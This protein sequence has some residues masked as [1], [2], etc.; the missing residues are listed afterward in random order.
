V[1]IPASDVGYIVVAILVSAIVHELGHALAAG[2]QEARVDAVGG[3]LALVFPGAYVQLAGIKNLSPFQQLK[4][5]C[6]GAWHNIVLGIICLTMVPI[7][8]SLL[9]L[10]YERGV[11]AMV[12]SMPEG[13]PLVGHLEAGDVISGLGM[14]NVS[15]GGRSFRSAVAQLVQSG[16]SAGFCISEALHRQYAHPESECCELV[17]RGQEHPRLQCFSV[18]DNVHPSHKRSCISPT[19][20]SNRQTCRVSRDCAGFSAPPSSA[21][22]SGASD[23]VGD[24]G[25]KRRQ[26]LNVDVDGRA[27]T[28]RKEPHNGEDFIHPLSAGEKMG[29][30]PQEHGLGVSSGSGGGGKATSAK[31][32]AGKVRRGASPQRCFVAVLPRGEKLIDIR[33]LSGQSGGVNHFFYQGYGSILGGSVTV[34][35]YVPRSWWVAPWWGR[36]VVAWLDVPN[37]VERQLQ[38]VASMS[39][40]LAVLNMAPVFWLDGEASVELFA[41]MLVPSLDSFRLAQLKSMMLTVGTGL[42]AL[43]LLLALID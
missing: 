13:S 7:L 4:V 43:N 3:F 1:T 27:A 20:A 42:L 36:K 5:Y 35:S 31:V 12:V 24:T 34:S 2:M 37:V 33:V 30:S 21:D 9:V 41:R 40:A 8:P 14:F 18:S 28:V 32:E 22:A 10:F 39:L 26:L 11:G 29:A 38:Y 17:D 19:V 25:G 6:A 23:S 15:D 16:D